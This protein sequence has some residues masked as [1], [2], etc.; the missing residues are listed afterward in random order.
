[1]TL[2]VA[3]KTTIIG[4]QTAGSDGANYRFQIMKG[5]WSSFTTYGVFYPNKKK[6]A[7]LV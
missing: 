5:I 1:M 3:P 6:R 7:V 2:K 4:S